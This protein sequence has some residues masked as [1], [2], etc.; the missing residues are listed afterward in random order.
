VLRHP[1]RRIVNVI[2]PD[3]NFV[4]GEVFLLFVDQISDE[5]WIEPNIVLDFCMVVEGFLQAGEKR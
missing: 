5:Q 4:S 2:V 3:V 1:V